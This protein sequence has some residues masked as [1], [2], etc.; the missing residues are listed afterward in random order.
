MIVSITLTSKVLDVLVVLDVVGGGV[1]GVSDLPVS[2]I[3]PART[4][5]DSAHIS[6]AAIA[7]FFIGVLLLVVLLDVE[8]DA[9]ILTYR[10]AFISFPKVSISHANYL[11]EAR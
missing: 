10:G 11:S 4:E 3:S 8:K 2:G 7:I 1:G 9:T 5:V 6:T